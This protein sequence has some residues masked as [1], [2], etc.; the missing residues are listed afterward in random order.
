MTTPR[1]R[2][3]ARSITAWAAVAVVTGAA[4]VLT[5]GCGSK[6]GDTSTAATTSPASADTTPG[7][8]APTSTPETAVAQVAGPGAVVIKDY[9][10]VPNSVTVKPGTTV[11]WTDDDTADHWVVSAPASPEAFDLGRQ[12]TGKA[13]THTFTKSGTYP[14]YCN[15]HNYMK[16]TVVVP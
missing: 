1:I 2:P 13:V 5:S 11:T 10:F 7:R 8:T 4:G 6:A 14:Y 15:L 12:G 9:D 16:G 3:R